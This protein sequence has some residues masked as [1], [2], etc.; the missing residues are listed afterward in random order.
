MVRTGKVYS[1]AS[2]LYLVHNNRVLHITTER[3]S[4]IGQNKGPVMTTAAHL[5]LWAPPLLALLPLKFEW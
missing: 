5:V 3:I 4:I 2:I 1:K